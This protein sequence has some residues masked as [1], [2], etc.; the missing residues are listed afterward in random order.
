VY[1]KLDGHSRIHPLLMSCDVSDVRQPIAVLKRCQS[2]CA[3]ARA[4]T[5]TL[6]PDNKY[7]NTPARLSVLG[8]K[9]EVEAAVPE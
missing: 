3:A 6:R 2:I 8:M 1:V 5:P 7:P 4:N 9:N